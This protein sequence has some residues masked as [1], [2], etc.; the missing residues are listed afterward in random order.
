[1]KVK[2]ERVNL[3]SRHRDWWNGV[4]PIQ[5]LGAVSTFSVL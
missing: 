3:D 2:V 4:E 5:I 1:M